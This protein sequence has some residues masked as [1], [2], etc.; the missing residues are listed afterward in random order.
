MT[1]DEWDAAMAELDRINATVRT[2]AVAVAADRLLAGEVDFDA[3]LSIEE[4]L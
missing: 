2:M 3:W 1:D 4:S